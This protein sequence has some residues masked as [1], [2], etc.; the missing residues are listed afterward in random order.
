MWLC[1]VLASLVLAGQP[2]SGQRY[3][4]HAYDPSPDAEQNTR[5]YMDT[6]WHN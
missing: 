5:A 1:W 2:V 3:M 4:V 6:E